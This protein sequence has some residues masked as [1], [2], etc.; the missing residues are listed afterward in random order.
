[1]SEP[2]A[3][4]SRGNIVMAGAVVVVAMA[5][6]GHRCLSLGCLGVP[7]FLKKPIK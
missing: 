2:A 7:T 4:D 3:G 1:M 6:R 5:S